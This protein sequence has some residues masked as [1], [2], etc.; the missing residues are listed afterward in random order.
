MIKKDSTKATGK[1]NVVVSDLNGKVKQDFT[2]SNL[3][4][5]TGLDHIAKAL[6]ANPAPTAMS[7]MAV[8]TGT[9]AAAAADTTLETEASGGRVTLTSTT[10]TDNSVAYVASYGAGVATAALTEAAILNASSAGTMLCRTVF[11]VIN[12]GAADTMTVTWTVTIS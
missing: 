10:A 3:V 2:V 5:D 11:P 9:T 6:E 8:G 4:V 7:H 12:K 1:V